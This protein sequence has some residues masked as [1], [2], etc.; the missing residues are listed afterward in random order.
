MKDKF[1]T[2][3][4]ITKTA[5]F[6][7]LMCICAWITI[8]SPFSGVPF[9]LQTFAVI[10]AGLLLT[11]TEALISGTVYI[12]LGVAGL[13]VFSNFNTL[14]TNLFS[15]TGGYII[16]LFI[17][18]SLIS[19]IRTALMKLTNQKSRVFIM[20]IVI[21]I[22]VGILIVDLPGVIVL[23]I[24]TGTNYA[25]AIVSGALLFMPTDILKCVLA[26]TVAAA[27]KKPLSKFL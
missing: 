10:L 3:Q 27:L 26:A 1:L 5:I 4:R 19:L 18:P 12:L 2:P 25:T 7:A 13:P 17:A 23:K 14:Y 9:T 6:A 21:S 20:Y 22:V 8:P 16:G 15:P 24:V 11:P